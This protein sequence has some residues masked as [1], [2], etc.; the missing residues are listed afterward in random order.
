MSDA[1]LLSAAAQYLT[2]HKLLASMGVLCDKQI[3]DSY[4]ANALRPMADSLEKRLKAQT[5]ME[6]EFLEA[7]ASS[8]R[9]G[10][11]LKGAALVRWLYPSSTSRYR[12]DLDILVHPGDAPWARQW[13]TDHGFEDPHWTVW[14]TQVALRN[15]KTGLVVDLHWR[16]SDHPIFHD[17]WNFE[18]LW[19]ASLP[20]EP[21]APNVRRL[22]AI[23]ALQHAVVHRQASL[24]GSGAK[25]LDLLDVKLLID[26]L[27]PADRSAFVLACRRK[28]IS[29]LAAAVLEDARFQFGSADEVLIGRL[30]EQGRSEWLS[31]LVCGR[32]NAPR[33]WMMALR[34]QPD[35]RERFSLARRA[36]FP[37]PE[38]IRAGDRVG[39]FGLVARYVW[40][41]IVGLSRVRLT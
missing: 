37:N 16:L 28:G 3:L 24:A 4:T 5:K 34:A 25:D 30:R 21:F 33:I 10:I 20:L 2:S 31:N 19:S 7:F 27:L 1:S 6:A 35:W 17:G 13:L 38:F 40:R 23:M 41:L 18:E 22:D 26:V 39:L 9:K 15:Q 11:C 36:L 32:R 14:G 29:G 12:G 8:G